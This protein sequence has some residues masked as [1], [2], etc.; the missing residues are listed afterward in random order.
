MSPTEPLIERPNIRLRVR[1][2]NGIFGLS[3]GACVNL[4]AGPSC[5]VHPCLKDV[6]G[7]SRLDVSDVQVGFE[8]VGVAAETAVAYLPAENGSPW[9]RGASPDLGGALWKAAQELPSGGFGRFHSGGRTRIRLRSIPIAD[10]HRQ[11]APVCIDLGGGVPKGH[12][13]CPP[14]P[15]TSSRFAV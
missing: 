11:V 12:Q 6:A 2:C 7:E 9:W 8:R 1:L 15:E 13:G 10:P 5:T 14:R 3:I 4:K